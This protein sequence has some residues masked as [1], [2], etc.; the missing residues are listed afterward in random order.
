MG[1]GGEGRR[2][3]ALCIPDL[4]AWWDVTDVFIL[5]QNLVQFGSSAMG[6]ILGHQG[7]LV[8]AGQSLASEVHIVLLIGAF[9]LILMS[10]HFLFFLSKSSAFTYF[11][12]ITIF[13]KAKPVLSILL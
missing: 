12:I 9:S 11:K 13:F 3:G 2:D 4:L 6:F 7:G 5:L 8:L 1:R 10:E